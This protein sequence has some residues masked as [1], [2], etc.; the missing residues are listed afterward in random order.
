MESIRKA[1]GTGKG[2]LG[3]KRGV[4]SMN[5]ISFCAA[6][7]SEDFVLIVPVNVVY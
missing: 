1:L 5:G 2:A 7:M 6:L 3:V 4:Q